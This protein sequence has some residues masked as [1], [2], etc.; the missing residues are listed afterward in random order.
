M[1]NTIEILKKQ[2]MQKIK[3][4]KKF[5]KHVYQAE[6]AW[7]QVIVLTIKT[8]RNSYGKEN[9]NWRISKRQVDEYHRQVY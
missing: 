9:N 4:Y 6:D 3:R 5:K 8:K 1:Q 7:K 2:N